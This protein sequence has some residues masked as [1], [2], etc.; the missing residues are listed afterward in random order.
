MNA[1][2]GI[3]TDSAGRA[4]PAAFAAL[5][6][7]ALAV[8]AVGLYAGRA[9]ILSPYPEDWI[10]WARTTLTWSGVFAVGVV[11]LAVGAIGAARS[12]LPVRRPVARAPEAELAA[13]PVADAPADASDAPDIEPEAVAAPSLAAHLGVES[14]EPAIFHDN[15]SDS[16]MSLTFGAPD[17]KAPPSAEIIPIRPDINVAPRDP[18]EAALLAEAPEPAVHREAPTDLNAV[19]TSTLR[20][21]PETAP[22]PV[23]ETLPEAQPETLPE[24]AAETLP[25]T[26]A[27]ALEAD[28][29]AE[30]RQAA[31]TALSVW[32]DATRAIA[33]DE[34][35]ARLARL[36]D[37]PAPDSA[38]AFRLIATGDL[39]GAANA[40]QQQ[41]SALAEAGQTSG[42]AEIWRI[43]GALHMGRDDARAM[44][45]Y[46]QVSALDASD[47][48][49]H[50]YLARRY[51]MAGDAA[52]QPDVIRRALYVISDPDTRA[53]LL[54]PYADL[55]LK[56]GD[57]KAG[58]DA[59][60]EL[61]RLHET[62]AHLKPDDVGARSAYA[63]SVAR[64]AQA[65]EMQGVFDQA[66][67]LYQK[68]HRV[69]SDLSAMKP[70]HP[71][72]R[73]LADKALQDA[74]R[75]QSA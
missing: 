43:F 23:Q 30:V 51:Q 29:E 7:L 49:I 41:A 65:R 16:F 14:L 53:E 8:C 17:L 47:A 40:L 11:L 52:R 33:A 54:A 61:S 22:E 21:A 37:D 68:A 45:A 60:E 63:V 32:P 20:F 5:A 74:R 56:A 39:N 48:N 26:P 71:G 35:S 28:P 58:G 3:R 15:A 44:H 34:L 31:Q 73:A 55:M 36:R 2:V 62:N 38:R 70:D 42:A 75:F 24:T 27:A 19:I 46:E 25:E 57:V 6:L 10:G 4:Q 50:L 18:L 69:F 9:P 59:L 72:L 67:P 12:L 66:A 13:P 64:L 1:S